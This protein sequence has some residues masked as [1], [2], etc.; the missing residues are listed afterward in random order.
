MVLSKDELFL[1]TC[2]TVWDSE[3]WDS[4]AAQIYPAVSLF[5]TTPSSEHE[6]IIV[7]YCSPYYSTAYSTSCEAAETYY[8]LNYPYYS[9]SNPTR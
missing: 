3:D 7:V 5:Q 6:H 4:G 9:D 2:E 1:E 8:S